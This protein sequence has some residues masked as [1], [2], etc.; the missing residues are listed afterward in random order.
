MTLNRLLEEN[1][2]AIDVKWARREKVSLLW[3]ASTAAAA[4]VTNDSFK[5][6][7]L[8]LQII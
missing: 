6:S 3:A 8:P 4:I 7:T 5:S 2:S 1:L